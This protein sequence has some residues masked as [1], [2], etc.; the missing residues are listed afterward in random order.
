VVDDGRVFAYKGFL[1]VLLLSYI[2]DKRGFLNLF[3]FTSQHEILVVATSAD[4]VITGG[5]LM[6]ILYDIHIPDHSPNIVFVQ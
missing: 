5:S 6:V 2:C 4:Y 3:L 1:L